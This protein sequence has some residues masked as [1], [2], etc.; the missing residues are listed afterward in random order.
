MMAVTSSKQWIHFLRSDRWPP[1]SNSLRGD[2]EAGVVGGGAQA[3]GR[4]CPVKL[5]GRRRRRG[6]HLPRAAPGAPLPVLKDRHS[7]SGGWGGLHCGLAHPRA[8]LA[9]R[10]SNTCPRVSRASPGQD[11]GFFYLCLTCSTR[12]PGIR[13][14]GMWGQDRGSQASVCEVTPGG[15]ATSRQC[16]RSPAAH[17]GLPCRGAQSAVFCSWGEP[18]SSQASVSPDV[19]GE[20]GSADP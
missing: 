2:R 12:H 13:P 16:L 18:C 14:I 11:T 5:R 15:H 10:E 1:T 17:L 4:G 19:L 6:W 3:G 9:R 20:G 8:V 7:R